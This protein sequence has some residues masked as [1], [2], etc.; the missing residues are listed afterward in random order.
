[1]HHAEDSGG[2]YRSRLA[3]VRINM[4]KIYEST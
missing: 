4:S 2:H 3:R 1:M